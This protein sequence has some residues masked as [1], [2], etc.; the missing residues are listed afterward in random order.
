MGT[1]GPGEYETESLGKL[2]S[3]ALSK[4]TI[5]KTSFG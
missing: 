5:R 3:I 4:D 1:S 2:I